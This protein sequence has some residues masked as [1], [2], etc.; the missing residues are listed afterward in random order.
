MYECGDLPVS[1]GDTADEIGEPDCTEMR[2]SPTR[3]G[4]KESF[5]QNT[6]RGSNSAGVTHQT[7]GFPD[8]IRRRTSHM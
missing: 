5:C 6:R 2:G 1:R 3:T 4:R 8:L 7:S